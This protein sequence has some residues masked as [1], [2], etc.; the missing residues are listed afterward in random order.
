MA[1]SRRSV[2][3]YHHPSVQ[4]PVAAPSCRRLASRRPLFGGVVAGGYTGILLALCA[5]LTFVAGVLNHAF[6][7]MVL[8][9]GLPFE[10]S[11][12]R[13]YPHHP[14]AA[15]AGGQPQSS[16][17]GRGSASSSSWV[18]SRIVIQFSESAFLVASPREWTFI[19][20]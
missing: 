15:N 19:F 17:S 6:G 7:R 14:E 11:G 20:S 13:A 5:W 8:P 4:M 18:T 3:P 2:D 12:Y 16:D 9:L 10:E 1:C